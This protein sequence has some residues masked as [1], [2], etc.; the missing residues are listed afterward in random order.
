MYVEARKETGCCVG[1]YWYLT[2]ATFFQR[3]CSAYHDCRTSHKFH[4][5][6]TSHPQDMCAMT[7]AGDTGACWCG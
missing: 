2:L 5:L 7:G 4:V 6:G 1:A 3:R